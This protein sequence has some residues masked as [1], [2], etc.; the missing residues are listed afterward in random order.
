M[1]NALADTNYFSNAQIGN[2]SNLDPK[3]I[4]QLNSTTQGSLFAPKMT[5][6]QRLLIT[7]PIP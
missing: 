6:A 4:L 1:L 3:L 5:T 2:V 7:P